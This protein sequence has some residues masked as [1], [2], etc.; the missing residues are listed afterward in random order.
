M[1]GKRKK[2]ETK[3]FYFGGLVGCSAGRSAHLGEG[4]HG[5]ALA[6]QL[7]AAPRPRRALTLAPPR[8]DL[9]LTSRTR[10]GSSS[11]RFA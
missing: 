7:A 2:L 9:R 5:G 4:V 10:Q 1:I 8:P 6:P 11:P 3:K